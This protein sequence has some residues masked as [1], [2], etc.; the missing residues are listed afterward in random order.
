MALESFKIF[1][2]NCNLSTYIYMNTCACKNQGMDIYSFYNGIKG[3][4]PFHQV[5]CSKELMQML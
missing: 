1:L 4:G 2:N 3:H 5:L